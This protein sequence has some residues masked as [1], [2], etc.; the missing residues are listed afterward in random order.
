M[1]RAFQSIEVGTLDLSGW[2]MRNVVSIHDMFLLTRGNFTVSTWD[3]KNVEPESMR[4][5]FWLSDHL[6]LGC[7]QGHPDAF[8]VQRIHGL[9]R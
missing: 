1:Y 9:Q 6:A 3:T 7:E 5:V 8:D 4:G 2:D